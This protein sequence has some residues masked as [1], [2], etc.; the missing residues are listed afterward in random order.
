[1]SNTFYAVVDD[2]GYLVILDFNDEIAPNAIFRTED[3]AYACL[4]RG[5]KE[6]HRVVPVNIAKES[7]S[8]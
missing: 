5:G 7:K 4:I 8:D 2:R 1:M 3:Q 6:N